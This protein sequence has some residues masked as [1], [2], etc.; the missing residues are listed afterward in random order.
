MSWIETHTG[1]K[2]EFLNPTP[3]MVC[4]EDIAHALSNLCRYGGHSSRF[5][6][7]AEHCL[8]CE[9]LADHDGC[10][11]SIRL[12]ALTHDA[13]EAYC[14]DVVRPLK[15]L[16]PG[17]KAIE[18]Q[19]EAVVDEYLGL[20]N[21]RAKHRVRC[22]SFDVRSLVAEASALMHCNNGWLDE[23]PIPEEWVIRWVQRGTYAVPPIAKTA[24]IRRCNQLSAEVER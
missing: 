23:W 17:Y 19:V 7:V 13:S 18:G 6:S 22:K 4:I 12:L 5:Y 20:T 24:W 11:D 3:E 21:L 2:F 14:Q 16:L 9:E 1:K 15:G 10:A 8:L